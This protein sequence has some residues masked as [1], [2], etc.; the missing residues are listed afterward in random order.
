MVFSVIILAKHTKNV[1]GFKLQV[2]SY[3]EPLRP[4]TR[5]LFFEGRTGDEY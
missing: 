1:S 2:S 4:E 5:N 3:M